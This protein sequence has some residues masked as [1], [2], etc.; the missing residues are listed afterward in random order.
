MENLLIADNLLPLAIVIFTMAFAKRLKEFIEIKMDLREAVIQG[1]ENVEYKNATRRHIKKMDRRLKNEF[2]VLTHQ[3]S[4]LGDLWSDVVT[5]G[6]GMNLECDTDF[7]MFFEE[8]KEILKSRCPYDECKE[9]MGFLRAF[10]DNFFHALLEETKTKNQ[11]YDW[12]GDFVFITQ[13]D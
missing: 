13:E 2:R 5:D 3:V 11:P 8:F 6:Y 4:M 9:A 10:E 7:N 12:V 1:S